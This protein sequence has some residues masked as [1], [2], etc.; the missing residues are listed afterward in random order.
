MNTMAAQSNE[1]RRHANST[2]QAPAN[3]TQKLE[4]SR[5]GVIAIPSEG[6]KL[7]EGY[8]NIAPDEVTRHV[9]GVVNITPSV[10][11]FRNRCHY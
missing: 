2:A 4:Y 11:Y 7:L 5:P 9:T 6:R 10:L 3:G 8:S 1:D